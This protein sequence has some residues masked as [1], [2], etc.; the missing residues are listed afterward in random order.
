MAET[1]TLTGHAATLY[2]H[3]RDHGSTYVMD[4]SRKLGIS[5]GRCSLVL[6]G[7]QEMG[8]LLSATRPGDRAG[9]ARRYYTVA[10]TTAKVV[11]EP[12]TGPSPKARTP[13]RKR[14][15][16]RGISRHYSARDIESLLRA[17]AEMVGGSGDTDSLT[18]RQISLAE[19]V[20]RRMMDEFDDGDVG[21]DVNGTESD[22]EFFSALRDHAHDHGVQVTWTALYARVRA[23]KLAMD[24]HRLLAFVGTLLAGHRA[25]DPVTAPAAGWAVV[26]AKPGDLVDGEVFSIDDGATWHACCNAW[27]QVVS[28]YQGS[29]RGEDS[30]VYRVDADLTAECLV[31]RRS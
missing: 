16:L 17:A 3:L 28:C 8:L 2:A 13:T 26:T 30:P 20:Y 23:G 15:T 1:I 18:Q 11:A 25:Y 22:Q 29:P 14:V 24:E 31:L 19:D 7:L 12:A 21:P 27:G 4:L 5:D 6:R 10:A 9:Q